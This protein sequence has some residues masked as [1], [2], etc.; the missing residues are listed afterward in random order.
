MVLLRNQCKIEIDED[1]GE[2]K[3]KAGNSE[4]DS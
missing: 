1:R 4:G 2:R 3:I